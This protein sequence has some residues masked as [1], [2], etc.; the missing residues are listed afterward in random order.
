MS[1]QGKKQQR[2]HD[3]LNTETKSYKAKEI[4]YGKRAFLRKSGED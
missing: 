3:L 1:E 2:T 4:F